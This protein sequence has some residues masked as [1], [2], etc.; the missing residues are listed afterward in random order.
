[1]NNLSLLSLFKLALK[2]IKLLIA[3]AVIS[4]I[5]A[6]AFCELVAVPRYSATGSLLVTNGAIISSSDTLNNYEN[7]TDSK[8]NV[9]GTDISASLQLSNTIIDILKTKDI[10]KDLAQN[11]DNEFAYQDLIARSNIQRRDTAT[12]FIDITFTASSV[13]EA[14]KLVNKYLEI[15]PDYILK[16]IPSATAAVTSTAETATKTYP[17]TLF[18]TLIAAM[19][20]AIV[21]Y[22]IIYLLSLFNTTI[23]NEDDLTNYYDY[24]IIGNIPDFS[25]ANSKGY[26]KYNYNAYLYSKGGG[27][28]NVKK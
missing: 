15:T 7:N 19:C 27:S 11:L 22:V 24:V 2:H 1:M 13:E 18:T 20:G 9:S 5:L 3:V 21:C 4:A 26:Y 28:A 10:Y 8:N 6:Y 17:Q 23:K 16:F 14:Q 12:L 25:S